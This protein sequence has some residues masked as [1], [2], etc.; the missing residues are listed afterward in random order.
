VADQA[1]VDLGH[2]R[3]GAVADRVDVDAG[4][5]LAGVVDDLED[6]AVQLV[7]RQAGLAVEFAV[8]ADVLGP[9]LLEAGEP[10]VLQREPAVLGPRL[11]A[12]VDGELAEGVGAVAA[13]SCSGPV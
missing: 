3:V 12:A 4:L 8:A 13:S 11:L 7:Q 5:V 9:L 6:E 2:M 1:V 10:D